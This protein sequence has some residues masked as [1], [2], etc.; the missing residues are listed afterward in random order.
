MLPALD[1]E[2]LARAEGTLVF[3]MAVGT[4][5]PITATL[6]SLGRDAREPALIV[7]R[8]GFADER[9][10]AGRLG[11]IAEQAR[12]GPGDASRHCSSSGRRSPRPR[13]PGA[14]AARGQWR[15]PASDMPDYFAAFLDLR[16]RRCL[17]VGG[18]PV[19]ERKVRSLLECGARVVLVS[20]TLTA[21]LA[22][23]VSRRAALRTARGH[24]RR[25]DVRGVHG[26]G[27]RDRL[28]RATDRA[29]AAAARPGARARDAVDRPASLRL[30]PAVGAEAR[31]SCRSRSPAGAAALRSPARSA[32]GWRRCSA[33]SM[34]GAG[35][36]PPARRAG[37]ARPGPRHPPPGPPPVSGRCAGR[38][39]A[40]T[41]NEL[42]RRRR[43]RDDTPYGRRCALLDVR[44]RSC[45]RDRE[46]EGLP[47]RGRRRGARA[48]RHL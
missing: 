22:T 43:S 6:Q 35:R 40:R 18:G 20:P 27:G 39:P 29:V 31:R 47:G 33:R 10:L 16:N 1:W 9:V 48:H 13:P 41:R 15:W 44:V 11:D 30:H 17:V 7:E 14:A 23:L 26:G 21:D 24:F 5:E 28:A 3:Y 38:W 34:R 19:G 45:R 25:A 42:G 32:A 46:E 2:L 37:A 12:Q 36:A 8:V 4:L